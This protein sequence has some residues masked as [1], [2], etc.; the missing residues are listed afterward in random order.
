MACEGIVIRHGYVELRSLG[1][2]GENGQS[3]RS[4]Q[5][6]ICQLPGHKD[7][8][9]LNRELKECARLYYDDRLHSTFKSP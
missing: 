3:N 2:N 9:D 5:A 1:L 8:G 4:D 7:N 6:E